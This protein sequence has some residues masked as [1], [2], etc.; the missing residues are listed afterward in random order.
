MDQ[1]DN[2]RLLTVCRRLPVCDESPSDETDLEPK[3]NKDAILSPTRQQLNHGKGNDVIKREDALRLLPGFKQFPLLESLVHP[4]H[5]YHQQF[6]DKCTQ[7]GSDDSVYNAARNIPNGGSSEFGTNQLCAAMSSV[8]T[9]D[10]RTERHDRVWLETQ[11]T[12]WRQSQGTPPGGRTGKAEAPL[13]ITSEPIETGASSNRLKT[14]QKETCATSFYKL[15]S[16]ENRANSDMF[17]SDDTPSKSQK[18]CSDDTHTKLEKLHLDD[19]PSK[20]ERLYSDET[21]AKSDEFY[22]DENLATPYCK[23]HSDENRATSDIFYSDETRASNATSLSFHHTE[24]TEK[25]CETSD[26]T[27][28]EDLNIMFNTENIDTNVDLSDYNNVSEMCA[29]IKTVGKLR[30]S[31]VWKRGPLP[32]LGSGPKSEGGKVGDGSW[33]D[34]WTQVKLLVN[35]FASETTAHGY[36]RTICAERSRTLRLVWLAAILGVASLVIF[37]LVQ[38]MRQRQTYSF[39]SS[40]RSQPEERLPFPAVTVCNLNPYNPAQIADSLAAN[41]SAVLRGFLREVVSL[42]RI[43]WSNQSEAALRPFTTRDL[44]QLTGWTVASFLKVCD[45]QGQALDCSNVFQRSVT[46]DQTCFTFNSDPAHPL[47]TDRQGASSGLGLLVNLGHQTLAQGALGISGVKVLL[48]E[49]GQ[50]PNVREMGML[51]A[52]GTLTYLNVIRRQYHFL[53]SPFKAYG[54][55]YCSDA[56]TGSG[57]VTAEARQSLYTNYT[58]YS[59][60]VADCRLRRIIELCGCVAYGG[61]PE[62][63]GVPY[64]SMDVYARCYLPTL[65]EFHVTSRA[66]S[67]CGCTL[68]CS[69]VEHSAGVSTA[70]YPLS[71]S[72]DLIVDFGDEI[73]QGFP[74]APSNNKTMYLELKIFFDDLVTHVEEHLPMYTWPTVLGNIGGQLGLLTGASVLTVLEFLELTALLAWLT[75][76]RAAGG[77]TFRRARQRLLT[78]FR[79]RISPGRRWWGGQRSTGVSGHRCWERGDEDLF[80]NIV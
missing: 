5:Q 53:P 74:S 35:G 15:Y 21:C 10:G 59:A 41:H 25:I 49:P 42:G 40:I 30:P 34:Y 33:P 43:Q 56:P 12:I 71:D 67:E 28:A 72:D 70:R 1:E 7:T 11:E 26:R 79:R 51:A 75:M 27:L 39:S 4:F 16:D 73:Y 80:Y 13:G 14:G 22:S 62:V 8:V 44:S 9:W 63:A 57:D 19:T 2:W 69:K 68:P 50:L 23:F 48:H 55:D 31:V 61:D 3:V 58:G 38:V 32:S 66:K 64:C 54:T 37:E 17:Y 24:G 76:K 6:K 52:P 36:K 60:C 47:W 78:L 45:W 46:G 65:K 18:F 77:G 20:S 29:S